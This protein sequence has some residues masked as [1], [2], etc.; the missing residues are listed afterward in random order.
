AMTARQVFIVGAIGG[1]SMA[2][3]LVA[4][5]GLSLAV[6]AGITRLADLHR[7]SR[8]RRSAVRAAEAD[9]TTCQAID[10]LST[11]DHTE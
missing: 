8:T 11:R 4:F 3:G 7:L 5:V 10:A 6:H 2:L 9:L 1:L